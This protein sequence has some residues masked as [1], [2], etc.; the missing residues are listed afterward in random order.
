MADCL[1]SRALEIVMQLKNR[2]NAVIAVFGVLAVVLAVG[3]YVFSLN[4]QFRPA[5][6]TNEAVKSD[7]R[8]ATV[9]NDV[10]NHAVRK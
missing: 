1:H 3:L 10:A 8:D 4:G 7:Q 2:A 6:F 9:S 5:A